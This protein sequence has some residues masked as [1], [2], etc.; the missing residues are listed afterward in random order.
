MC[1]I[2]TVAALS[3]STARAGEPPD[4]CAVSEEEREALEAECL[5][6]TAVNVRLAHCPKEVCV[7]AKRVA[8]L[9]SLT[10]LDDRPVAE[11]AFRRAV[12]RLT[13]TGHFRSAVV[14]CRP[15]GGGVEVTIDTCA[16]GVVRSV[17]ITGNRYFREREIRKR[18]FLRPGQVLNVDPRF[19]RE[20]ESVQRQVLALERL[21]QREGVALRVAPKLKVERLGEVALKVTV[22]LEEALRDGVQG[23]TARHVALTKAPSKATA[24][25]TVA[26][27]K[28]EDLVGYSRGDVVSRRGVK[29]AEKRL[30]KYFR[31]V[32]F[33]SPKANVRQTKDRSGTDIL[34]AEVRTTSCWDIRLW[35]RDAAIGATQGPAYR[36]HDPVGQTAAPS[37]RAPYRRLPL[38]EWRTS[39]P[40]SE[41]GVFDRTEASRGLD[42]LRKRMEANGF[43]FADVRLEHRPN[44]GQLGPTLGR[45]EYFIT[46]N[47]QRRL[48][49]I[50]FIGL[51][52]FDEDEIG[53]VVSTK[54]YAFLDGTT[55]LQVAKVMD[56]LANLQRFYRDL[57][58]YR[59]RFG[60]TGEASDKGITVTSRLE[61]GWHVWEYRLFDRGFRIKKQVGDMQLY[62]EV[63]LTEGPQT[64][65]GALGLIGD[66]PQGQ[67][68]GRGAAATATLL[69]RG[70]LLK[71][72]TLR[73]GKPFGTKL[74]K[75]DVK[76]IDGWYRQRGYHAVKVTV[77]CESFEPEPPDGLC[78]PRRV[79]GNRVDLVFRV[80]QGRKFTVGEVL[81]R[82]NFKTDA[83]ILIRD[84]PAP[85]EPFNSDKVDDALRRMRRLGIF[86]AA[87]VDVIGLDEKPPRSKVA[88]VVTV[89]EAPARYVDLSLSFRNI[90]RAEIG[91]V[92][93]LLAAVAGLSVAGSDRASTGLARPAAVSLPDL[94][95]VLGFE[96]VD[97][98]VL[99]LAQELRIPVEFGLS[100]LSPVRLA[101]LS[102][103]WTIPWRI[104]DQDIRV[105]WALNAVL[106]D[107]VTEVKDF[108]EFSGGVTLTLPLPEQM[109]VAFEVSGGANSFAEPSAGVHPIEGPYDPFVR[110]ALR[111]RWDQQDNP[112][113]PRSG[114]ALS[115]S[116]S[117]V[118]ATELD[119]SLGE[120]E[121]REFFKWE[122][123]ARVAVDLNAFV[124]AGYFRYAGSTADAA[125][126]LPLR[127]RYSLGGS[128]GLRGFED[129]AVGRYDKDGELI[130]LEGTDRLDTGGN[131]LVNF[132][133]E[134]RFPLIP[135]IWVF[136]VVFT[137]IGALAA[138][139]S[140][141]YPS[142]FRFSAGVGL[143]LLLFEQIPVR[144]DFGFPLERRCAAYYTDSS[145]VGAGGDVTDCAREEDTMNFHFNILYPF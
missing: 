103:T 3:P 47:Y 65:V 88:L 30:E 144:V 77:T 41:S 62:L 108:S 109:V 133:M 95:L 139:H 136:G 26:P 20:N 82:G 58:F 59:F 53:K 120:V 121:A 91:A 106:S 76:A 73:K 72:L 145:Q 101:K 64:H 140:E 22:V 46:T 54:S 124:L 122:A 31:S 127:E 33:V 113:N 132:N 24:C 74:L 45:V 115:A 110:G 117:G 86:N 9:I 92:P 71:L 99:G 13:K 28:I 100:T 19:P 114:F 129:N 126:P 93:P 51:K 60:I 43:F 131:V 141:L 42:A 32:G 123:S 16:N 57:G 2:T 39:L 135:S 116:F 14:R 111:W 90:D 63:P 7:D 67:D 128:N 48:Q 69:T 23:I 35:T 34:L 75:D 98:N 138:E 83:D 68:G 37:D 118:I 4:R 12:A 6:R 61:G 49:G 56:D 112:L 119:S 18:V 50:R 21:Y 142:S 8:A 97:L 55:H 52:A 27:E 96:Y 11:Q 105:Q 15:S 40:F 102:P 125:T 70:K 134:L 81:W 84:L 107:Q 10:D 1:A 137:D 5:G 36:F 79:Q 104:D 87:S 66:S 130:R 143:R 78:D 89:E 38:E 25:P 17:E 29:S 85:G 94:L 44:R 80:S